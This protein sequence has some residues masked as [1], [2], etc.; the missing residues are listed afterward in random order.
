MTSEIKA[1]IHILPHIKLSIGS[2]HSYFVI[3]TL[4]S[5]CD[6]MFPLTGFS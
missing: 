2:L 1:F 6:A 4:I 5:G 3:F